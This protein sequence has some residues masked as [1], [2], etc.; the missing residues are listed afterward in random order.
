[1]LAEQLEAQDILLDLTIAP[2]EPLTPGNGQNTGEKKEKL[3]LEEK[4]KKADS[5]STSTNASTN[6]EADASEKKTASSRSSRWAGRPPC[7]SEEA[8]F[9][10]S[11]NWRPGRQYRPPRC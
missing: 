1:M 6:N 5:N 2:F 7:E 9:R 4:E 8:S 11:C 3:A 10:S